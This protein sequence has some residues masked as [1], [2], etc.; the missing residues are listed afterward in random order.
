[1]CAAMLLCAFS[2]VG[3]ATRLSA[4]SLSSFSAEPL[5]DSGDVWLLPNFLIDME[6]DWLR[7]L[8]AGSPERNKLYESGEF[9]LYHKA[10]DSVLAGIV[11]R[12]ANLTGIPSSPDESMRLSITR[13]IASL[14]NGTMQP[15]IARHGGPSVTRL[16]HDQNK[17]PRRVVTLLSFVS[18]YAD[19][20]HGGE[21]V[22]PCVKPRGDTDT[23][24]SPRSPS[25][26]P[27]ATPLRSL[28]LPLPPPSAAPPISP[29]PWLPSPPP[30]LTP[31]PPAFP[32]E[33]CAS[34]IESFNSG[35]H[36]FSDA[37]DEMCS[38]LRFDSRVCFDARMSALAAHLCDEAKP[39]THWLRIVPRRGTA[40]LF[41]SA[42]PSSATPLAHMW[43][44]GCP[45]RTGEKIT[46]QLFKEQPQRERMFVRPV[47]KD[48]I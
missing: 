39:A 8:A 34:L 1:M 15:A 21:T 4:A 22:F 44:G 7:R 42:E 35:E 3:G 31:S 28:Q 5:D 32:T 38:D 45:V 41:V 12:V 33:L 36:S 14:K 26:T 37:D 40:L 24:L 25:Q 13:S 18:D 10:S 17:A 9:S 46:I 16:H 23:M 20:L 27:S 19:G 48:E 11:E 43:H 47:D 2:T 29:C 6:I 30:S